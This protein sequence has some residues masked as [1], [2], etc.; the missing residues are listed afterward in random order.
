MEWTT[1]L[2]PAI[3]GPLLIFSGDLSKPREII[4]IVYLTKVHIGKTASKPLRYL[5]IEIN[6]RILAIVPAAQYILPLRYIAMQP[7]RLA[8]YGDEG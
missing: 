2:F 1:G 7:K 4:L 8:V 3:A 5:S 6:A